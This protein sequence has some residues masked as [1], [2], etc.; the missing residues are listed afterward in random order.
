M[1]PGAHRSLEN[2]LLELN[3]VFG[4]CERIRG[5]PIP[6]IYTAHTSRL[7]VFYL[8]LLPCALLEQVKSS[9]IVGATAL[10]GKVFVF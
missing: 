1:P 9:V 4:I 8:V 6:P 2:N 5:S 10:I 3:R 7:L